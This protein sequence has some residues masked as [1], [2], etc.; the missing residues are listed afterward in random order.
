MAGSLREI[1][2]IGIFLY[3]GSF[4]LQSF[5][6]SCDFKSFMVMCLLFIE[7]IKFILH[8]ENT[9]SFNTFPTFD[10]QHVNTTYTH[11]WKPEQF[12]ISLSFYTYLHPS[13]FLHNKDL[14]PGVNMKVQIF[15]AFNIGYLCFE[16]LLC[17]K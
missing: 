11:M 13:I 14:N 6:Y 8:N 17:C 5:P 12:P 7:A 9:L 16:S 3:F 1:Y 10:K 15:W 2:Y 4:S